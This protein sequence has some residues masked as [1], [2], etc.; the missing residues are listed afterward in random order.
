MSQAN[1]IIELPSELHRLRD[2]DRLLQRYSQIKKIK[3]KVE[4]MTALFE[5]H[6]DLQEH[7][8]LF[9]D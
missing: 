9:N 4:K 8:D 3:D 1:K 6:L 2:A 5:W 7:N